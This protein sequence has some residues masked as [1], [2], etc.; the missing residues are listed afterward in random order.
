MR[1]SAPPFTDPCHYGVDIDSRDNLIANHHTIEEIRQ[2]IGA[3][4]LGYLSMEDVVH[5]TADDDGDRFCTACFSG[6]YPTE[7]PSDTR[8]NRFEGKISESAK[9]R[10]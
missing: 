8:K 3:D 2:I 10:G 4:S 9:E 5:L 6:E 7:V 1:V